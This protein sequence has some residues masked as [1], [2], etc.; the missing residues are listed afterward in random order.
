MIYEFGLLELEVFVLGCS[1]I[2]Y[3]IRIEK[4]VSKLVTIIEHCPN[5]PH[6]IQEI[7]GDE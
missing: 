3:I 1:V 2:S 7:N 6:K 4:V 5:C